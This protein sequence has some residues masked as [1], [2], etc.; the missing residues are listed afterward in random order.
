MSSFTKPLI[1]K[2][3]DGH[4]WELV[5]G[6]EY[7][8]PDYTIKVPQGFITDFASIPMIFWSIVGSPTGKYG[9]AAVIHDYLYVTQTFSRRKADKILLEAMKV[10]K[11]RWWKRRV[12]WFAVRL[13]GRKAWNS[14]KKDR[15]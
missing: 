13:F 4:W 15:A 6:F 12:T 5:E 11:V 7:W 1:V 8:T 2:Y 9:K 10:L 3:L 14:H